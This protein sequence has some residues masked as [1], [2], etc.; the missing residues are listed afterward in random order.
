MINSLVNIITLAGS[1]VFLAAALY[2]PGSPEDRAFG[3]LCALC[4][5]SAGAF[6]NYYLMQETR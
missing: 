5:P 6:A 2:L 3:V 4:L 1:L